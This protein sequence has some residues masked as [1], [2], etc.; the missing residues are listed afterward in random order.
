MT[1]N[2]DA[3]RLEFA[4]VTRLDA[5]IRS[6][7]IEEGRRSVFVSFATD[8][9]LDESVSF[10]SLFF[11]SFLYESRANRECKRAKRRGGSIV[12]CDAYF[13]EFLI[14]VTAN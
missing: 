5:G 9:P 14:D 12:L 1:G 8:D 4:W 10:S 13:Y 11:S 7:L 3:V 6:G 2:D